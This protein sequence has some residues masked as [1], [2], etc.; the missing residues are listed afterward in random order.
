MYPVGVPQSLPLTSPEGA[1]TVRLLCCNRER[2][3]CAIAFDES[4]ALFFTFPPVCLVN[5]QSSKAD[6]ERTG[7]CERLLWKPDSSFILAS[8][9]KDFLLLFKV[10]VNWDA[11]EHVMHQEP[12]IFGSITRRNAKIARLIPKVRL[13]LT[14]TIDL[15]SRITC[16]VTLKEEFLVSHRDGIVH[17]F[18]WDGQIVE[19]L[20]WSVAQI[21]FFNDQTQSRPQY[22]S[23][24]SNLPTEPLPY[25]LDICYSSFLGGFLIVLDSGRAALV[26]APSPR[27]HPNEL[28]AIWVPGI[29]DACC[30]SAN[31]RYRLMAFGCLSSTVYVCHIDDSTGA[32]LLTYKADLSTVG[33]P[34]LTRH[35]GGVQYLDWSPSGSSLVVTWKSS[36][37]GCWSVFGSRLWFKPDLVEG[38]HSIIRFDWSREGHHVWMITRSELFILLLL[39]SCDCDSLAMVRYANVKINPLENFPL[40]GQEVC[41]RIV[42]HTH[43][44]VF[45][46]PENQIGE[47]QTPWPLSFWHQIHVPTEYLSYCWP[48]R[49]CHFDPA[50]KLICVAGT[51]GFTYYS[52]ASKKWRLFG[53]EM[54]ERQFIVGCSLRFW[55]G[56]LLCACFD[57]EEETDELRFYPIAERLDNSN[58]VR[59]NVEAPILLLTIRDD[60]LM[61]FDMV[62]KCTLFTLSADV[63]KKQQPTVRAEKRTIIVLSDLVPHPFCV[64]VAQAFSRGVD[65]TE[66]KFCNTIDTVL[67]NI[68]GR[69]IMLT[70]QA[71]GS[72]RSNPEEINSAHLD[73]PLLIASFVEDI[74]CGVSKN[75]LKSHLS[76]AIWI[77]S[78]IRGVHV[79]MPLIPRESQESN[80][81]Q[82]K[83]FISKWIMLA[84]DLKSVYPLVVCS[85]KCFFLG[86]ESETDGSLSLLE[87]KREVFLHHILKQLLKRNLGVYAWDIAT[88]CRDLPYFEHVLELLLHSVLEEEGTCSDPIP[89]PLLPRVVEFLREFPEFLQVIAH[90]ARKTE[91]ALWKYLFQVTGSPKVLFQLCLKEKRLETAASYFI[92]LQSMES[93][94]DSKK[95]AT[96]LLQAVLEN[97]KWAIALEIIRFL[98]SIDP[99]D[100]D[101]P[102]ITPL[103]FTKQSA[104]PRVSIISPSNKGEDNMFIYA[105]YGGSRSRHQSTS[106]A[107]VV[108]A[109]GP[110]LSRLS[111]CESSAGWEM[112]KGVHATMAKEKG[113][114]NLVGNKTSSLSMEG[115]VQGILSSHAAQLI[116]QYRLYDLAMFALQVHFRLI[117][118]LMQERNKAAKVTH[119]PVAL[120]KLQSDFHVKMP[121]IEAHLVNAKTAFHARNSA[122]NRAA[123]VVES[124]EKTT[125]EL[126][127]QLNLELLEDPRF[128]SSASR[129]ALLRFLQRVMLETG[130]F[131]WLLLISVMLNDLKTFHSAVIRYGG[132][133][134]LEKS[135]ITNMKSG[136]DDLLVWAPKSCPSLIPLI[137]AAAHLLNEENNGASSVRLSNGLSSC[138][139]KPSSS[140]SMSL[141]S[142]TVQEMDGY[143]TGTFGKVPAS[144]SGNFAQAFAPQEQR[145]LESVGDLVNPLS[146]QTPSQ[147]CLM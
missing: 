40:F 121:R 95:L 61:T 86:V 8:T 123:S 57:F 70:P 5:L 120:E 50:E 96:V 136:L 84:F 119:Y 48:V 15:S 142:T 103:I 112:H 114:E 133:E 28:R 124:K 104:Q 11:A 109:D 66:A 113:S 94:S 135:V 72:R 41:E 36:G 18:L 97:C 20:C 4:L 16:F 107:T 56:F 38:K 93:T 3:F 26:T 100:M 7:Y 62:A 143:R 42:L 9:C 74:W 129:E 130:C 111:S 101:S 13:V 138:S 88:T 59:V 63:T 89:D 81:T 90:C 78:G 146:P 37:I 21:P 44:R 117:L 45:L 55:R 69:L 82:S 33:N 1:A 87:Y 54:Q 83:S 106:A 80:P 29:F 137:D 46:S 39:K 131:D 52:I 122:F 27:F 141:T 147:C 51:R 14:S 17:R 34:E 139:R 115:F 134:Y 65:S 128:V 140:S 47:A 68:A 22:A 91:M 108:H 49:S 144:M 25:L 99:A 12:D 132:S 67:V 126:V 71:V 24:L 98:K 60:V 105:G 118:W 19:D 53:S 110:A 2:E 125:E 6:L 30:C 73:A 145:H 32:I 79:W 127:G 75:S 76:H 31:H 102:P 10:S 77:N 85:L 58:C 23:C 116:S 92:I 64:I 43:D 35:L